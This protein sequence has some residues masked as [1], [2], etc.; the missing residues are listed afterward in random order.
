MFEI[1]KA[2]VSDSSRHERE[3]DTPIPSDQREN[4]L[5]TRAVIVEYQQAQPSFDALLLG[6]VKFTR[7]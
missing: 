7:D 3:T 6:P 5:D 1:P 2:T 4:V